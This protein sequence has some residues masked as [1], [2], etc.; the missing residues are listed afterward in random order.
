MKA[1]F[2]IL[3]WSGGLGGGGVV[4]GWTNHGLMSDGGMMG[5]T[6]WLFILSKRSFVLRV[7]DN[8]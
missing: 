3:F 8:R 2:W 6:G 1:D 5:W 4:S 7:N